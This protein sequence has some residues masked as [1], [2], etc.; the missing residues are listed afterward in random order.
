MDIH[1]YQAK[2]LLKQYHIPI[3]PG[4]P[5]LTIAEA[6]AAAETL[7]GALWVVKAQIHAGGRGKAGGV[8]IAHRTAAAK[9]LGKPL[10]TAQT[11]PEG[12]MVHR[13]YIESGCVIAQEFYL[14][15]VVDRSVGCITIVAC[16]A[17][18]M[19]IEA[20]AAETPEKILRHSINPLI[21]IS[22]F[23][24]RE[25][26]GVL[27]LETQARGQLETLLKELYRA[28]VEKD[29]N[30][31]EINPLVLTSAGDLMALDAKMTFDDNSFYRQPDIFAFQD[32]DAQDPL[33]IE[34]SRHDLSYIKLKGTI[35]CMVN[36]AGLAMATMD[37]IK[38]HGA[39]P[40]N[41]LDVGGGAT[42]EKVAAALKI[43]LADPHVEAILVN[44]FGGIMRCDV[45]ADGIIAAAQ[46][47]A[48]K[49]PLVVRLQGTN[50]A[51]GKHILE[52]SNLKIIAADNLEEAALKVVA[53][54]QGA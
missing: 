31:I 33:E 26:A 37:I 21:G 16:A 17:G 25:I 30:L 19:D 29:A 5:A 23:H 12:Q 1:E 13:V 15:L 47:V 45:I 34:A 20:V 7:G 4:L 39:E 41:F 10:V 46:E 42:Q 53:A 54:V 38:L 35:G 9:L 18:G 8:I 43:I 52:Q 14:S 2:Q 22:G 36:G 24:A 11:G 51:Q 40:A 44:I 32:R 6:T 28:F 3:P 48:V 50:A 27:G 49:V